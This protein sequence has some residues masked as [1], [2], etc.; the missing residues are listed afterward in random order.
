MPVRWT[1]TIALAATLVAAAPAS[2][3]RRADGVNAY[4]VRG[5]VS[6]GYLAGTTV[7]A[8]LA[9]AWGLAASETGPW[10]VAN[11]STDTSTLY[12][13]AGQKRALV[14]T[15]PGGPTGVVFNGTSG[16]VVRR[17]M[18]RTSS[19]SPRCAS[20]ASRWSRASTP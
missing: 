2:S 7:D 6:D 1:L 12:D 4:V 9:N 3:A 15:V 19:P 8:N 18:V 10:W 17:G 14:V 11:E 13:G 20:P 5:L 16:F